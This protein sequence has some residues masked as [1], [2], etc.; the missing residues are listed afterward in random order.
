M[1]KI[2]NFKRLV[3]VTQDYYPSADGIAT[4]CYEFGIRLK[5]RFDEVIILTRTYDDLSSDDASHPLPIIRA[6]GNKWRSKKYR[7]LVSLVRNLADNDTL[8]FCAHWRMAVPCLYLSMFRKVHFFTAV[9]G[10]DALEKRW[11]NRILQKKVFQKAY[12]Y[13]FNSRFS[14]KLIAD[15]NLLINK[16]KIINLAVDGRFKPKPRDRDI[17]SKYGF[18][19]GR[20]ILSVGRLIKR[21]G[22]DMTIKALKYMKIKDVHYYIAGRGQDEK[23][24][25][26][27]AVKEGMNDRVHF[28]GYVPDE[29]FVDLYNCGDVFSMPSRKVGY[30][31]VEGFGL[32]FIE[33]GA[34]GLP[35]IGGK[36][37][38]AEDAIDDGKTG[39]LVNPEAPKEIA[40]TIDKLLTDNKLRESMSKAAIT[41][42]KI[43]F[44]WDKKTQELLEFISEFDINKDKS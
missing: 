37:S 13:I 33:A 22:F 23:Y 24:L 41:K 31:D 20:R 1:S 14:R 19:P 35:A 15:Q 6:N 5:K 27:T 34:C 36:N 30:N 32:T 39:I 4:W 3:I 7:R 26:D 11:L 12:G 44:S 21:K 28:L 38:G 16:N 43:D 2:N 8:F 29:D 9:H 17:E 40:G 18:Q 10:S 25:R 42:A